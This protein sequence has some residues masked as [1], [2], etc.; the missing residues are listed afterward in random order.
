MHAYNWFWFVCTIQSGPGACVQLFFVSARAQLVLVCTCNLFCAWYDACVNLPLVVVSACN[1]FG[2]TGACVQ[3]V[4]FRCARVFAFSFGARN[5]FWLC[6]VCVCV[7]A[8]GFSFD[9]RVRATCNCFWCVCTIGFSFDACVQL[10]LVH[11]T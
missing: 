7:C 5:W 1:L 9:A 2:L 11:I 8:I 10:T 4:L 3:L 6:L